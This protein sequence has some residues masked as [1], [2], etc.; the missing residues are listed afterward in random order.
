MVAGSWEVRLAAAQA[1]AKIGIRSGEP[2]RVQCYSMLAT[3][4]SSS[5]AAGAPDAPAAGAPAPGGAAG[6]GVGA[7]AGGGAPGGGASAGADA[8]AGL[9]GEGRDPLGVAACVGPAL[10]V[11]DHMYAGAAPGPLDAG[12]TVATGLHPAP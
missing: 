1:I 12:S 3:A 7:S 6:F 4:R 9:A 5:A 8:A 10:E 2:F 11:M